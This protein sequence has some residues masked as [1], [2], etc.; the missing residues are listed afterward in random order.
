MS[1]DPQS[2][3]SLESSRSG[4][5]SRG[6]SIRIPHACRGGIPFAAPGNSTVIRGDTPGDS[7]SAPPIRTRLHGIGGAGP[8]GTLE[9]QAFNLPTSGLPGSIR[10]RRRSGSLPRVRA[11]S[12]LLPSSEAN[13]QT[14]KSSL[15]KSDIKPSREQA[16]RA[17]IRLRSVMD[18]PADGMSAP[19]H[20]LGV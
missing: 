13:G 9:S 3:A 5:A 8:P 15:L 19:R 18:G 6:I 12:R 7:E 10:G 1:R 20:R 4:T 11:A 14:F 2:F 17:E 16:S